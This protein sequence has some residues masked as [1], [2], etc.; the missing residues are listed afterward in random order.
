[1]TRPQSTAQNG[2]RHVLAERGAD[3]VVVVA[4]THGQ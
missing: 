1:M 2:E 3:L 4:T